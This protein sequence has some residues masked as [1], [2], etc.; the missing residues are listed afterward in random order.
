MGWGVFLVPASN[1]RRAPAVDNG[2]LEYAT[3]AA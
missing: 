1:A 3:R 2:A